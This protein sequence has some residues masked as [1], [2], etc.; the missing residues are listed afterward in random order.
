MLKYKY[1]TKETI[2]SGLTAAAVLVNFLT[3]LFTVIKGG[4]D[5]L[6]ASERYF[7]NGIT[8][9]FSGYPIIIEDCGV[10]LSVYSKFHFV[11]SLGLIL[12]LVV[13]WCV[14]QKPFGKIEIAS[15]I[16]CEAMSLTYLING[17]AAYS[18]ASEFADLYFDIYTLAFLPFIIITVLFCAVIA[19]KRKMPNDFKFSDK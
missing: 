4:A 5:Y 16:V 9:A 2:I 3:L 15:F 19:V 12:L 1:T 6:S 10:W 11:A 7:A 13:F 14:N 17:C 18:V 8:L